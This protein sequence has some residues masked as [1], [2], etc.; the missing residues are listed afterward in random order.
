[1][2]LSISF[3]VVFYRTS[4]H[5]LGRQMPPP[6]AEQGHRPGDFDFGGFLQ[7]RVSQ[8]RDDLLEKLILL[9]IG[10]LIVGSAISYILARRTLLPIEEAMEMQSRF[11]SDAS[12]ELRTPLAIM[13]AE[14][15]V[16]LRSKDLT[17]RRAKELLRSNLEESVKLKELS[18]GLL[19]L[20]QKDQGVID[21][22]SVSLVDIAS[23]AMN[24]IVKS[25]QEKSVV[26]LDE[27]P[28][29]LVIADRQQLIHA[30]TILLDNAVK[31]S[32]AESTVH[33]SGYSKGRSGYL[34]VRDEGIGIPEDALGH[35]FD[36]FY[37][38]DLSRT[39]N[40]RD[41]YGLGL[42]IAHKIVQQL[43]GEITVESTVGK[44]SI[45]TIKLP[46]AQLS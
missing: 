22:E 4:W 27:A 20:A 41:G 33:I 17:L 36:R 26:L 31:Y 25:A 6:Y 1:M 11:A 28:N 34:V 43:D 35:I 15:E 16:A 24:H 14:N 10:A 2:T 45:F 30:L 40:Q 19:R 13:Q 32:D 38:V 21:I 42:S 18:E 7:N 46:L 23:E 5:E 44:G 12:H 3:S 39:K 9:N 29:I 8:G 37:R